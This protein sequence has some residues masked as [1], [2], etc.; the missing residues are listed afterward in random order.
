MKIAFVGYAPDLDPTT[1]G[2]ITNCGAL[3][4]SMRGMKGA[5]NAQ[6]AGLAALAAACRGAATLTKL[7]GSNRVFAGT[8]T[9]L[10]EVASG[11][12]TDRTR[13][14]GAYTLGA[15]TRWRFAQFGDKSLA[16]AKSDILQSSTTG[17]FANVAANAPKAS[18]VET[19]NNFVF[20]FDVNDQGAIYDSADRPDGW[21]C[22][23]IS[24]E[25]VWTP[26]IADQAATG[27]LT[28]APGKIRAGRRF[29]DAIVAY[30]DRAMYLGVYTGRPSIWEFREVPGNVGA[31]CQEVVVNVGTPEN[32]RHI[33]MGF[34]DFYSFDGAKPVP[35]GNDLKVT[36]FTELNRARSEH[37][38]ALHDRT[39]SLVY[40]Y[41]PVAD[42]LNPDKCVVY[43]YKTGKWGRDDRQIQMAFEYI[44]ASKT[45]ADIGTD[46]STYGNLPEVSYGSA[47]W[48]AGY[49]KPAIFNTSN[50]LQTLDAAA[51]NVSLTTWD[52]GDDEYESLLS[53]VTPRY[54]TAPTTGQ[55]I[56][57]YRQTIGDSLTTDATTS[58]SSGR[59]DVLR[60][61]RWHRLRFDWTGNV[62][63]PGI[64]L[65]LTKQGSE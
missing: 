6:S 45:Y 21:W 43:N 47:F 3:V 49:S 48:T 25:T 37:C 34:E 42:S 24:D 39:N 28:S 16:A 29:G 32:P 64:V 55:M 10:Y 56:N 20:L 17:A 14:S 30:K 9:A 11:A 63:L 50:V 41:Y 36:V 65:D 27:R 60:E 31:L 40:F 58:Q 26:S 15:S 61:A 7:D 1:K 19:V 13:A 8:A 4:P 38:I 44:Q 18:I 23:K 52:M 2:V 33:F 62:E 22:S 57:Y 12:W 54:L 35:I 59:F 46:Y 5:P 51:A 53:R